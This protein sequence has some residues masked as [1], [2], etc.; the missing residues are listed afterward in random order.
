MQKCRTEHILILP[1]EKSK[2]VRFSNFFLLLT[3]H[4]HYLVLPQLLTTHGRFLY[5]SSSSVSRISSRE[6][7]FGLIVDLINILL[8]FP[9]TVLVMLPFD[10][11]QKQYRRLIFFAGDAIIFSCLYKIC[12][13][14]ISTL[15]SSHHIQ[16]VSSLLIA[17]GR[18]FRRDQDSNNYRDSFSPLFMPAAFPPYVQGKRLCFFVIQFRQN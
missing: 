7:D 9:M 1:N 10:P 4:R 14:Q 3:F 15:P 18:P 6:Y 8:P 11:D 5:L 17:R 16:D 13:F 12:I 2:V